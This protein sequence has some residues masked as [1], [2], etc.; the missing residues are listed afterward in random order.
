MS[1]NFWYS[2]S[3]KDDDVVVSSRIRLARNLCNVAFPLKLNKETAKFVVEKVVSAVEQSNELSPYNFSFL[4]L[5]KINRVEKMSLLER[6]LVSPDLVQKDFGTAII[7]SEDESLSIMINEEDHLRIQS[8]QSG[9][10]LDEL[11]ASADKADTLLDEKLS[12]AFDDTLGYLTQCP[13]NLGTGMRASLMLHLPAL[14][15]SGLINKITKNLL[16]LG[17]TMRGMYGEGTEPVGD[18]YQLSNQVTLGLSEK[19]AIKNLK[20]IASQLISQERSLRNELKR[21]INIQDEIHRSFGLLTNCRLLGV[22]EFMNLASNLRFGISVGELPNFSFGTLNSLMF[23]VQNASILISQGKEAT[24]SGQE[25]NRIRADIVRS[26]LSSK[27][28]IK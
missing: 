20:D 9:F 21:S 27:Q 5:S 24:T 8:M 22:N 1:K 2:L 10:D 12:F 13:T 16:K 17:L 3:G 6:H 25:Q 4:D 15:R 11:F 28:N 18:M 23:K 7:A 26:A 14:K 19:A